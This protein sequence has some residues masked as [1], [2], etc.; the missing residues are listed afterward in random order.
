MTIEYSPFYTSG[1]IDFNVSFKKLY[2]QVK[3]TFFPFASNKKELAKKDLKKLCTPVAHIEFKVL[4][5]EK[6]IYQS[7]FLMPAQALHIVED[8][9]NCNINQVAKMI[10][11]QTGFEGR[12]DTYIK[13]N[14][15]KSQLSLF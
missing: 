1:D 15:A 12:I 10:A 8:L 5:V 9:G 6:S 3:V 7:F 11:E 4:E 2:Y 13:S 14:E